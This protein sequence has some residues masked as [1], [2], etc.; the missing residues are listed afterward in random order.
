MLYVEDSFDCPIQVYPSNLEHQKSS[1]MDD[2]V[3]YHKAIG[4][5]FR[6]LRNYQYVSGTIVSERNIV[7]RTFD[8]RR[9]EVQKE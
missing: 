3:Y 1:D 5:C 2:Y 9:L 4:V 7:K 6:S 8:K